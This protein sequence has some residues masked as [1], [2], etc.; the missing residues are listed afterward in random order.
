MR[1]VEL[2]SDVLVAIVGGISD[3][4]DIAKAYKNYDKEFPNREEAGRQFKDSLSWIVNEVSDTVR[5]TRFRNPAWFYSLMVATTDMLSGIP[6]G[7][8]L[9]RPHS[10]FKIRGRMLDLD[11][12]LNAPELPAG[13]VRLH[14]ALSRAT[15][16]IPERRVRHEF[17]YA[18][19]TQSDKAWRDMWV[20]ELNQH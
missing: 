9:R 5:V 10:S 12:A 2:T 20:R 13:L 6:Q 4:T 16:H 1:E 14:R 3:I 15:S 18:M 8:G 17:L 7:M 11:A 19:I